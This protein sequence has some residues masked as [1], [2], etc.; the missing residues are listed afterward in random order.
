VIYFTWPPGW[1]LLLAPLGVSATH[2]FAELATRGVAEGART[3]IRSHRESLVTNSLSAP[4]AQWLAEWPT[5]GGTSFE[6]LQQVLRRVPDAIRQME[7]R[8]SA[9]V[10]E[11]ETSK[12]PVPAQV[13]P[14]TANAPEARG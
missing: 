8:V 6:K 14:S 2:Q 4:L 9:K 11:L 3:R 12:P 5:T 10:R 1:L 13:S 7:E